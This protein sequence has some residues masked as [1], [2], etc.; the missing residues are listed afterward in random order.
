MTD[1]KVSGNLVLRFGCRG[2][3]DLQWEGSYYPDDLPGDWQLGYYANDCDCVLV[4]GEELLAE[5]PD[6]LTEAIE[7]LPDGFRFLI[8]G[9]DSSTLSEIASKTGQH[10]GGSIEKLEDEIQLFDVELPLN[11]RELRA[12]LEKLPEN[13]RFLVFRGNGVNPYVIGQVR[14]LA[15]LM[16]IA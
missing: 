13:C 5:D 12:E 14:Q 10:Y 1:S 16:G 8:S 9:A 6:Q 7:D 11:M 3:R 2:W 15:E 4:S